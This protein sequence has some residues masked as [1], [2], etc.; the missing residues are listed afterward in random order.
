VPDITYRE[1]GRGKGR[2]KGGKEGRNR[3]EWVGQDGDG[4]G[5]G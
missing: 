3:I 1:E 2:R 5:E 4:K